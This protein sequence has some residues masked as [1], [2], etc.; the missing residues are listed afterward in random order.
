MNV[1]QADFEPSP[2]PVVDPPS[3]LD[4]LAL[5]VLALCERPGLD[6]LGRL[7]GV[8]FEGRVVGQDGREGCVGDEQELERG[9]RGEESRGRVDRRE[10]GEGLLG[11]GCS[12]VERLMDLFTIQAQR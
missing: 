3:D 2:F 5:L 11:E 8:D 9:R 6:T 7:G 4:D 1:V 12:T 10:E